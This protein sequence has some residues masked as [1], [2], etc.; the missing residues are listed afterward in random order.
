MAYAANATIQGFAL[1]LSLILAIGA[2]NAFVLRQG[3]WRR[4]VFAVALICALSDA[5]LIAIGVAGFAQITEGLPGLVPVLTYGGA[6]F[7][8]VYGALA[9]RSAWRGTGALVAGDEEA[10]QRFWVVISTCLAL[11]WLNPHVY[12]DTVVLMGSVATRYEGARLP[13]AVGAM[14]SSFVFFFS[15]AYGAR[16]LQPFFARPAAWRILDL[17]VAFVMWSIAASLIL[18]G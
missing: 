7:L 2:Q 1:G 11:T 8:F 16:L 14:T 13:F 15:L 10:G 9:L 5:V 18:A 4:H 17:F 12:L 6:L 3:L